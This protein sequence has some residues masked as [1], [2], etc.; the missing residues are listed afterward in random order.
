MQTGKTDQDHAADDNDDCH[1]DHHL[2]HGKP[3]IRALPV[4]A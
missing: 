1:H 3:G 2:H 4:R